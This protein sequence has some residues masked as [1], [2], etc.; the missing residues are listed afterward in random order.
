[1]QREKTR[2]Y[3]NK[4]RP[5]RALYVFSSDQIPYYEA[6]NIWYK[7]YNTPWYKR[8]QLE[9][10]QQFDITMVDLRIWPMQNYNAH[11]FVK[12]LVQPYF[13]A[14]LVKFIPQSKFFI[15]IKYSVILTSLWI[16]C[17]YSLFSY[18]RIAIKLLTLQDTLQKTLWARM[19]QPNTGA[20]FPC[21]PQ[22]H[23]EAHLPT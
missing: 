4:S 20:R 7:A 13:M 9:A 16:N 22:R 6:I 5:Q 23:V 10:F 12:S 2:P 15:H 17:L 18:V 8:G 21:R 14:R 11:L 3:D 1:M 19:S